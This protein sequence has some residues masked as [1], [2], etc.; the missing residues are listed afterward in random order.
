MKKFIFTTAVALLTSQLTAAIILAMSS[1]GD[2][3]YQ[4]IAPGNSIFGSDYCVLQ[5]TSDFVTW[6]SISTNMFPWYG[7]G[8]GVTNII[9]VT[10]V[11]EFYRVKTQLH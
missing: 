2:G 8:Y 11:M 10:N 6:T 3:K 4:I 7:Q 5:S 9:Q 1:L